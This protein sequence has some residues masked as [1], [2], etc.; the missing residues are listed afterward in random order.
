MS[1]E[2]CIT[3]I[4]DP[5]L[6]LKAQKSTASG[7]GRRSKL[8]ESHCDSY[9]PTD[10]GKLVERLRRKDRTQGSLFLYG[11]RPSP[12]D[13]VWKD[14]EKNQ[15]KTSIYHTDGG[16]ENKS[17]N[18]MSIDITVK[19]VELQV[20]AQLRAKHFCDLQAAKEKDKTIFIILAGYRNIVPAI[21]RVLECKIRVELWVWKSGI[22]Q[23]Y[24]DLAA[25]NSLLSVH[26]LDSIFKDI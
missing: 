14:C 13:S 1:K 16:E 23:V 6:W 21:K 5:N 18:S 8:Q 9:L 22:S 15:F 19:A 10:V 20:E 17:N 24:V 26:L 3:F 12:N 7:K 11:S 25:I 2:T 4:D